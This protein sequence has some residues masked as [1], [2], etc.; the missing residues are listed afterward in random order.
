MKNALDVYEEG[1][2]SGDLAFC[3]SLGETL[4]PVPRWHADLGPGE[5]SVVERCVGS[6]LDVGCGPGRLAAYL[7]ED[8][9]SS[10]GIDISEAAVDLT[11]ERGATALHLDVFAREVPDGF[12]SALLVDGNI[13]IGGDPIALLRRVSQLVVPSG[14]ILVELSSPGSGSK[15]TLVSLRSGTSE[16]ETFPWSQV[17]A[18][19]VD[20]L[21]ESAGLHVVESWS[22]ADVPSRRFFA[23]LS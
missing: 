2:I 9:H 5:M 23:L 18:R 10:L 22:V 7:S 3:S 6:V 12:D 17:D 16:S 11:R 4:A 8:G 19:D 13:G 15:T 21:A 14:R 1:L 20:V